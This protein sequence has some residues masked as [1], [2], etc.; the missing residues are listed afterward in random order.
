MLY[1]TWAG[2][3]QSVK[4]LAMGWMTRVQFPA[5]AGIFFFTTASNRQILGVHTVIYPVGNV[6]KCVA[7]HSLPTCADSKN[8][9]F[10]LS[11]W[12]SSHNIHILCTPS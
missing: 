3:I 2:A 12:G 4:W 6:V 11:T 10:Y 1:K 8:G 9:K 5:G 7:N